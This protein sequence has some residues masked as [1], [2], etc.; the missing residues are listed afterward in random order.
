T[1]NPARL[2]LRY[3][4]TPAAVKLELDHARR[5][6]G[7]PAT[8]TLLAARDRRQTVADFDNY[9]H[10]ERVGFNEYDVR[11]RALFSYLESNGQRFE[12]V[13]KAE[14]A[15]LIPA[16]GRKKG[17]ARDKSIAAVA[18]LA[19]NAARAAGLIPPEDFGVTREQLIAGFAQLESGQ[20][21]T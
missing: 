8:L 18:A 10:D 17:E 5:T 21:S 9:L 3:L 1:Q 19:P 6:A 12:E 13:L 14:A 4:A 7:Q 11:V 15:R 16:A 20:Q 2:D